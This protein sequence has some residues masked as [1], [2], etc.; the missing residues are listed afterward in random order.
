MTKYYITDYTTDAG[1]SIEILQAWEYDNNND[2]YI[3]LLSKKILNNA[4]CNEEIL[5]CQDPYSECYSGCQ[6]DY[7]EYIKLA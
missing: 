5:C 1:E 6:I 4:T 2:C 7:E 3:K